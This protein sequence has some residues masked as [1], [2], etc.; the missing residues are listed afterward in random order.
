VD[1]PRAFPV[2]AECTLSNVTPHHP[3]LLLLDHTDPQCFF[4]CCL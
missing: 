2:L 4:N 1:R 3:L